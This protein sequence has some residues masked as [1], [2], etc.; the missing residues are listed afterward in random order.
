MAADDIG[1]SVSPLPFLGALAIVVLVV[2]GIGAVTISR[3]GADNER[4]AVVRAVLAQNDALQ[5]L[6]YPGYRANT[7]SALSGAEADV[8][9]RQRDSSAAKGAR[10]VDNVAGVSVG[11]D[12]ATA[13]V[14]YSFGRSRDA[15]IDTAMTF[16]REDGVWRV[17][18][19]GPQ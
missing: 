8:L 15:T 17:C 18:S 1:T 10:Y 16:A 5:R 11:G 12:S 7:C 2:I 9:A 19:P 6:D 14:T 4:E 13:S 3:R